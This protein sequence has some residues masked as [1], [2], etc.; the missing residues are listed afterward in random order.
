MYVIQFSATADSA[1]TQGMELCSDDDDGDD[2]SHPI[3]EATGR[4][5]RKKR[6]GGSNGDASVPRSFLNF[7]QYVHI[8][9]KLRNQWHSIELPQ[10]IIVAEVLQFCIRLYF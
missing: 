9:E 5:G 1:S 4:N 2:D 3:Y 7:T 6:N 10:T 8:W